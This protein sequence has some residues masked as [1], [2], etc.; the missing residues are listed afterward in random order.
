MCTTLIT[1]DTK[2]PAEIT[3]FNLGLPRNLK[4]YD[5]INALFLHS[6]YF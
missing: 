3:N 5:S 2:F 6:Y 1:H 4:K